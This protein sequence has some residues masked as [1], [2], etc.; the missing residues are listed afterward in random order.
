M[1]EVVRLDLPLFFSPTAP[2]I[3][4]RKCLSIDAPAEILTELK[5]KHGQIGHSV[6]SGVNLLEVESEILCAESGGPSLFITY[7]WLSAMRSIAV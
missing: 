7:A 2:W 5:Y 1:I 4:F 3:F 6:F